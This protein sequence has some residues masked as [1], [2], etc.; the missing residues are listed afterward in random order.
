MPSSVDLATNDYQDFGLYVSC[1][2]KR[3]VP[4]MQIGVSWEKSCGESCF[5]LSIRVVVLV[6]SLAYHLH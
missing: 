5:D 3:F 2:N 6:D 1:R 4:L